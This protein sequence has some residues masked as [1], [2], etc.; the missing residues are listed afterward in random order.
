MA[1]PQF[2]DRLTVGALSAGSTRGWLLARGL[3]LPCALGRTG[4]ARDK[5]EGDGASPAG[6]FGLRHAFYR[7]DRLARPSCGL[8]LR[9]LHPDDGWCDD[10]ASPL[11]N[12]PVRHPF[13]ASAE[14]LWRADGLYDLIVVIGCND[15]PVRR[16]RG[17]AIFLHCAAPGLA[18]TAGCVALAR[19]DLLRLMPRLGPKT[20]LAIG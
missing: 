15:A 10:S 8:P 5:R 6:T 9:A 12:R 3:A 1:S 19:A 2:V 7:P 17:S 4:I 13:A 11:Y 18:P 20:L 16:G 14:R